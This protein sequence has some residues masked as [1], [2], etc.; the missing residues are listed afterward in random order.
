MRLTRTK[1][2]LVGLALAVTTACGGNAGSE[3]SGEEGRGRQGRGQVAP[4][5]QPHEGARRQGR[6]HHRREVR[7]AGAR[8][9]GRSRPTYRR[10]S[11]SRSPRSSSAA[12]GID[13]ASDKVKWVETISDN[14][15]P[16][17][18]EGQGRPGARVVLHHRR[19]RADGRPGRALHGHRPAGAG[20]EGQR[21]QGHRGPQGQGG[22]L[23]RRVRPRSRTSTRRARRASASTT[24]SACVENVWPAPS[25]PC[26][27]TVRSCWVTRH[28]TRA[29]SRSSATSSPRSA[30]GSATS[31]DYPEMC[32]WITE[33]LQKA[34]DNG[35][36]AAGLRRHA[37][38]VRGRD[39]RAARSWTPARAERRERPG[40]AT[41]PPR[42]VTPPTRQP[43]R[44]CP[45]TRPDRQLSTWS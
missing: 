18:A 9:Q 44:R 30:S 26:P 20:E 43:E 25:R 14:R 13:P 11:T 5:R 45:E 32:E 23:G 3:D 37:R 22:L 27:P 17:L 28:R 41:S 31:K 35:D 36:W 34:F 4:C 42:P 19:A 39:A 10:A 40:W 12:L 38:Q 6:D 15:E 24:Y 1:V 8:F 21:H 29:S 33:T 7:P 16:F 2:V